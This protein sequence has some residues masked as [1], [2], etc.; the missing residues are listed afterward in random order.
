MANVIADMDELGRIVR[1]HRKRA[2]L[3]RAALSDLAGTGTTVIY[4]LEHGKS[5]LQFDVLKRILSTLNLKLLV[6]GPLLDEYMSKA[7]EAS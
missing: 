2:G 6:D 7:N 5:T 3:S 4:E 1:Y